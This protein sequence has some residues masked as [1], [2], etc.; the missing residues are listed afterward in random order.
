MDT[1]EPHAVDGGR[2]IEIFGDAA[3][4]AVAQHC[5]AFT[6]AGGGG[7][8]AQRYFPQKQLY[9]TRGRSDD[10]GD[11]ESRLQGSHQ[12]GPVTRAQLPRQGGEP[13]R[14]GGGRDGTSGKREAAPPKPNGAINI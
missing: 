6:L 13:G 12:V 9:C 7:H 3:D 14:I 8:A 5:N 2:F 10:R 4:R 1:D 11:D